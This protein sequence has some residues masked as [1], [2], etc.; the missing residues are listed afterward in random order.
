MLLAGRSQLGRTGAG[1]RGCGWFRG[2]SGCRGGML[3]GPLLA[4]PGP[5]VSPAGSLGLGQ[6]GGYLGRAGGGGQFGP[7]LF[8]T[9]L[10]RGQPVAGVQ[11][12]LSAPLPVG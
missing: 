10:G 11:G 7:L 9:G 5:G 8:Q 4:F 2:C 12:V 6:R 3:P 1:C